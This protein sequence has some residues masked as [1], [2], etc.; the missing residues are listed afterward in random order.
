M[1]PPSGEGTKGHRMAGTAAVDET[2][3]RAA[4]A[5][6]GYAEP[7]L[8]E[9]A[10]G[11]VN[12][13]HSHDFAARALVLDGGFE[14][15]VDGRTRSLR[16]GDTFAVPAGVVHEEVVGPSGARLLSGRK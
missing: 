8:V 1:A 11:Q 10:P 5:R 4:L 7:V 9:W 14:L 15:T 16:A 3:F 12:D 2:V 6:D 13:T